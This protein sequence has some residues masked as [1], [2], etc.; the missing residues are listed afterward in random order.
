MPSQNATL[1]GDAPISSDLLG[2]YL[3]FSIILC[4][5]IGPEPISHIIYT[6]KSEVVRC[7]LPPQSPVQFSFPDFPPK[8]HPVACPPSCSVTHLSPLR[9]VLFARNDLVSSR[10]RTP[11]FGVGFSQAALL[12]LVSLLFN[13]MPS[14]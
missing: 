4:D 12:I 8:F 10:F 6:P 11:G 5:F 7:S 1:E 13:G 9:C 14:K 3:P 2:L